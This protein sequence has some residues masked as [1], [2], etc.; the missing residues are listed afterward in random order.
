M[1]TSPP[2]PL[3]QAFKPTPALA[4]CVTDLWIWEIPLGARA[5]DASALTLLPDGHPTLCFVYGAPLTASDGVARFTT[6]SAV[7]GFQFRPVQLSCAGHAAGITVRF[8]PW[9][10]SR[11]VPAS[12][13]AFAGRRVE[14]RDLCSPA[15]VEALESELFDLPTPVARVRRVERFL[16]HLMQAR[17]QSRLVEAAVGRLAQGGADTRMGQLARELGATERTLERHFRRAIGVA[18]KSFSRVMRL[19]AA[20]TPV[21]GPARWSEVALDAGYCDQAHLIRDSRALF[22]TPPA[23]FVSPLDN[24]IAQGF[25][26]LAQQTALAT[27]IFR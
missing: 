23:R 4:D 19:Q 10:L 25:Q 3:M 5:P 18:P 12:L 22:G 20:L 14:I 17:G 21:A 1:A 2:A 16:L 6:R 13:E 11:F 7:C 9:A 27:T 24:P 8:K 15:Q 26:N